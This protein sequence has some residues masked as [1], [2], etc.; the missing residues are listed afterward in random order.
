VVYLDKLLNREAKRK[1]QRNRKKAKA[2]AHG[3]A[4]WADNAH[5]PAAGP[6]LGYVGRLG[7]SQAERK[8]QATSLVPGAY[9]LRRS[10]PGAGAI[11]LASRATQVGQRQARTLCS[12][13]GCVVLP[14]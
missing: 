8:G 10:R 13:R 1:G 5:A 14:L 2:G 9:A 11:A 6:Y 7:Q 3:P 12:T 4:G